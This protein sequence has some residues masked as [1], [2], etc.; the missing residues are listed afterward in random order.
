[1][2]KTNPFIEWLTLDLFYGLPN[3]RARAM[4]GGYGLY[5]DGK[6]FGIVVDKTVYLKVD[7][8]NRPDFERMASKPFEYRRSDGTKNV[9]LS[10]WS[11]PD[12]VIEHPE[13]A[14]RWAEKSLRIPRKTTV[15]KK[16]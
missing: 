10:Y 4:F 9:S 16:S 7:A 3:V 2:P 6:I 15:K 5:A 8:Q 13:E 14:K 11:L 1:M 12:E